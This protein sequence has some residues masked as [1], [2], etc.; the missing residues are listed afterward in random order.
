MS[1]NLSQTPKTAAIVEKI[2]IV[3]AQKAKTTTKHTMPKIARSTGQKSQFSPYQR[4]RYAHHNG[5][6]RWPTSFSIKH[7]TYQTLTIAYSIP[8]TK[9]PH[10]I[11]PIILP[12]QRETRGS[13]SEVRQIY[14][15]VISP[16]PDQ[17]LSYFS[18]KREVPFLKC[19]GF[20]GPLINIYYSR[21]SRNERYHLKFHPRRKQLIKKLN[22]YCYDLNS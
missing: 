12:L 9:L 10:L 17:S 22:Y 14:G 13:L 7:R 6:P 4:Y 20:T 19:I 18:E 2:A 8:A 3:R 5:K 15:M 11:P 1:K 21:L 16:P